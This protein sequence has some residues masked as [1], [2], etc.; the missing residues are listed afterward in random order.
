MAR[1]I[2]VRVECDPAC[3]AEARPCRFTLG[4][5]SVAV[6]EIIDRWYGPDYRYVKLRGSDGAMYI[7]RH[8]ETA[9]SWELTM[10]DARGC[11]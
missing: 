8:A 4:R 2:S 5:R 6:D 10:F 9:G 1:E 3:H 7:L 11:R